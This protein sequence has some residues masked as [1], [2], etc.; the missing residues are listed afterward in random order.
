[1]SEASHLKR[2]HPIQSHR[3]DTLQKKTAEHRPVVAGSEWQGEFD[4]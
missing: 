4:L 1:M 3:W 2:S